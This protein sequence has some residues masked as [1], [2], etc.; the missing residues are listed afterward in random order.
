[1]R[2]FLLVLFIISIASSASA[3]EYSRL[4]GSFLM[5]GEI[6]KGDTIKFLTEFA[7]WENPPTI[8]H[9]NSKGGDLNEALKIGRIIRDSQIP[10]WSGEE[11]Y[12]ACVF[13]FSAGVERYAQGNIGLHRP[14]F[15]KLYF[16]G[17][18]SSEAK[19]KYEELKKESINYLKEMSVNQQIIDRMFAT[20]S[21]NVDI[22]N[23]E[24]ANNV[25]GNILPFYEEWIT[26]KCGKF[27]D[28]QIKVLSSLASLKAAR[29]TVAISQDSDIP[30]SEG[31]GSNVEKFMED[32]Q[33]ALQME[34]AGMLE[35]YIELSEI[36]DKCVEKATNKHIYSFHYTIK[37]YLL[38]LSEQKTPK[39]E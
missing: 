31:F 38:E 19:L 10:I 34:K 17:L 11:C 26:A 9:I 28:E 3:I 13:I 1:M 4:G 27:T 35:P 7:S 22:L 15:D 21:T 6:T 12:S 8:F 37:H 18:S 2:S 30:K 36:K 25:F 29:M 32:A 33:L 23:K 5:D 24:E 16:S 39:E 20:D 14:Y